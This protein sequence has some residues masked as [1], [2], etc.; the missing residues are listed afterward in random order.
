MTSETKNGTTI[1]PDV[2]KLL[3]T[4]TEA[5]QR[6]EPSTETADPLPII[7]A[8]ICIFLLL[9]T[10]VSFVTLCNPAGLD[11]SRYGPYEC[12]P[13]HIEDASEPRLK[14]WKRLGSLRRSINSFRRNRSLVQPQQN[15]TSQC[16]ADQNDSDLAESTKM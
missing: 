1:M 4:T 12:M 6:T 8:L 14:L 15:S 10:C 5:L 9:V 3:L 7:I 11:S 2:L 16:Q 13:Y